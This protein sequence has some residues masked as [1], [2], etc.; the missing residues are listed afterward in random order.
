MPGKLVDKMKQREG[1][2]LESQRK[3][4][5]YESVQKVGQSSGVEASAP[6]GASC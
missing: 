1:E 4:E 5:L 2:L 6:A 3:R